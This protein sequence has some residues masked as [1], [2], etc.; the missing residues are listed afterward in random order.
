MCAAAT[1]PVITYCDV[2]QHVRPGSVQR[3]RTR[4][5]K[6]NDVRDRV[7][8]RLTREHRSWLMSRVRGVDTGPEVLLRQA[9]WRRG[10]RGWRL[11]RR[12]LPGTPDLVFTRARLAVFVDGA[13]WHGH[14]RYLR[15]GRSGPY[16]D[17]KIEANRRRDRR[18]RSRLRRLG[19][20][21]VRIWDFEVR[22]SPATAAERVAQYL[23]Q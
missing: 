4:P 1:P 11:H 19:W 16:W 23:A 13:F 21:V 15:E 6:H 22:R 14:P 18:S 12:D 9:L 5:G 7:T 8:D 3:Q 17:Q 10:V 2:N 20:R